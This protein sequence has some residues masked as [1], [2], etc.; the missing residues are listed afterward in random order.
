MTL[1]VE[2]WK[3]ITDDRQKIF[4]TIGGVV[5]QDFGHVEEG[6][7]FSCTVTLKKSDAAIIFGYWHNRTLVDVEDEGGEIYKNLRVLVKSYGY[8]SGFQ[9]YLRVQLEFWRV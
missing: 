2:N 3:I 4:E 8:L 9:K 1:S 6:D 7:K 5:V